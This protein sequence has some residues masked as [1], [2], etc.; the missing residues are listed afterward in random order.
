MKIGYLGPQGTFT[1]QAAL[2]IRDDWL[3]SCR[4]SMADALPEEE[5]CSSYPEVCDLPAIEDVMQGVS[6]GI[7]DLAV[8]P[9]ENST[10]G[11]VNITLDSL[12]FDQDLHI[13]RQLTLPI[14]H[15]LMRKPGAIQGDPEKIYSHSQSLAQCRRYLR[16]RFPG[17]ELVHMPS[18]AEAARFV[19]GS[20]G[21]FAA[22][23]P[24]LAAQIYSLET[25]ACGIQDQASNSTTF[26]ALAKGSGSKAIIAGKTTIAFSTL[27]KPGSLYK[28]LDIFSLWDINMTKII[29]R[30]MK[31][32]PG[33]YVFYVDLEDYV[34]KDLED[35]LTMVRR[36]TNFFKFLGSYPYP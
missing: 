24:K 13:K 14:S 36:K 10:E 18:N 5:S 31:N 21:N 12:I 25:E 4:D 28:I 3:E 7:L 20:G 22:V 33:E 17:A 8:V 1:H 29:S 23:G 32:K 34:A 11:V 15:C 6:D 26:A 35:A 2:I 27:N 9:L 19:K 30:P 16:S